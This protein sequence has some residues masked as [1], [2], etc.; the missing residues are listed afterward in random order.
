M[1]DNIRTKA[2][3]R[4]PLLG[5]I[6]FALIFLSACASTKPPPGVVP[7]SPF[8]IGRY[9]GRWYELARLDH[10]FERGMTD[11]SATYTREPDGTVKVQNRGFDP[12]SGR[13]KEAIG[14]ARF[15]GAPDVASLKVSFFGPFYGGYH[16]AAL[17]PDYRWALVLGPDTGYCWILAREKH[18]DDAQLK[19]IV[20]RARALGVDTASLIWVSHNRTDPA[21]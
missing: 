18:L 11:V 3:L 7:V 13:W 6:S 21:Q 20:A 10:S 1:R 12:A 5:L 15:T 19:Q 8:D 4:L 16:V 2:S 9:E 17:D 14:K